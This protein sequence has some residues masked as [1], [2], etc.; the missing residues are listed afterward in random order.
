MKFNKITSTDSIKDIIKSISDMDLDVE[1]LWG[2]DIDS[3]TVINSCGKFMEKDF[4]SL[5]CT[6]RANIQMNMT[7]SKEERYVSISVDE[8]SREKI[9]ENH[10]IYDKVTY[11]ISAT[12]EL[13]F[14]AHIEEYKKNHGD[15]NFNLAE[16]F[17][18]REN[19]K[20]HIEEIYWFDISNL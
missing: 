20:I 2:Y 10:K 9:T 14:K 15:V 11:H 1:G 5:L 6:L 4:E 17:K 12:K 8:I 19:C 7:L 16:H 3:S 18:K 13:E